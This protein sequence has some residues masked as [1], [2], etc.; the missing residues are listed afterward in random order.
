MATEDVAE[1]F[2]RNCHRVVTSLDLATELEILLTF[3]RPI[4]PSTTSN[5]LKT[6]G[7]LC[8]WVYLTAQRSI[9]ADMAAVLSQPLSSGEIDQHPSGYHRA[10]CRTAIQVW[11]P[12]A[13]QAL[14]IH[15]EST[16]PWLM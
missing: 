1:W 8:P 5:P 4:Q 12:P 16:G 14:A 11:N 7:S 10:V 13:F 9:D 2:D 6:G 15:L 3:E